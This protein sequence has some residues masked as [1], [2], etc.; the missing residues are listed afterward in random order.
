[1]YPKVVVAPCMSAWSSSAILYAVVIAATKPRLPRD[2]TALWR[3][4]GVDSI[5]FC[6]WY[7][8]LVGALS[9][10]FVAKELVIVTNVTNVK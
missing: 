1:M 2:G 9:N 5:Q 10:V 8:Q 4:A 7:L 3:K 6:C